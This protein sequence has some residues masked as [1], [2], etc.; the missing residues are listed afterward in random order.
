M[1]SGK[2]KEKDIRV[3]QGL[4]GFETFLGI[5][6]VDFEAGCEKVALRMVESVNS[7]LCFLNFYF[8]LLPHWG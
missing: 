8:V 2:R 6:A 4:L 7:L 3:I 5:Q 1:G